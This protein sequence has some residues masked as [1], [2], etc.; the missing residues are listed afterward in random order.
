M[1]VVEVLAEIDEWLTRFGKRSLHLYTG[2]DEYVGPIV[3]VDCIDIMIA[4]AKVTG[5]DAFIEAS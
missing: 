4:M 2:G 1:T 5:T 3:D